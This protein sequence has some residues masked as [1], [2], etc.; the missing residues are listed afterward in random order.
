MTR[1]RQTPWSRDSVIGKEI[2][3]ETPVAQHVAAISRIRA[4]SAALDSEHCPNDGEQLCANQ[5]AKCAFHLVIA[6]PFVPPENIALGVFRYAYP[7]PG[8]HRSVG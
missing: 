3:R 5:C 4:A 2:I 6:P 8:G 7:D 1:T